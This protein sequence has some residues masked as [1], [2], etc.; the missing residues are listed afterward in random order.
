MRHNDFGQPVGDP[1]S[2]TPGEPLG[3][4]S[5]AGRHCRLEPLTEAAFGPLYDALVTGSP[6][7]LWTYLPSGPF[8][9]RAAFAD[10]L[11]G[12]LGL[13]DSV[14]LAVL[15]PDGTPVGVAT[16]LRIDH[17]RG[18]AEVGH[19]TYG[20]R[21]QRTAAATE[22]MFLMMQHA[23][24]TAGVRRYEWKCDSLNAPSRRAA[25]RLGFT[26]EG[27]F[28]QA[29]VYKDRNRD[30]AWYSI[31]DREWP[32]VREAHLRWL[33][34]TN[35]DAEGHQLSPLSGSLS[36]PVATVLGMDDKQALTGQ[37]ILDAGL[38]SW[39]KVLDRLVVRF[40]TGNF[41]AG[42]AL[43]GE[44]ARLADAANHHPDVELRY[45]H[46]TVSLKS[47][48]VN[49]ITQRDLRLARQISEAAAAAGVSASAARA[50]RA[51]AGS[52][53][54]RP[55]ADRAVLGR[56][57]R[58]RRQGRRGHRPRRAA[59]ERLV[60]AVGLPGPRPAALAPR[61]ER[62]ARRRAAADPGRARRGRH[63]GQRR[64][65]PRVLGAR[66]R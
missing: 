17:E 21:L 14:A 1:V 58:L 15:L 61:R 44:I 41:N 47:H 24:E 20:A 5:L 37:Q 18:T 6:D 63:P 3:P 16:W 28:R 57:A 53:H 33:A 56:A 49:A 10:H 59:A 9:D 35:F 40:A 29:L 7:S 45:P 38:E 64:A 19:I 55:R 25:V 31:T 4:V 46:V 50:R 30:T 52:R 48:D 36:V 13:P 66:R 34:E 11:R 22:A 8:T 62:A 12:L 60:P 32:T 2:W 43:V 51:R 39:R 54:P 23:F 42:T 65:R 27:V 26:F